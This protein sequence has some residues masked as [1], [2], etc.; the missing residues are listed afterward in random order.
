[1][2]RTSGGGS[3]IQSRRSSLN[4]S[5]GPNHVQLQHATDRINTWRQNVDGGGS[6]SN[7]ASNGNR[8]SWGGTPT[9]SER[10][11]SPSK[12]GRASMNASAATLASEARKQPYLS[13]PIPRSQHPGSP[14]GS[15]VSRG[16]F[17]SNTTT[18]REQKR[19]SAM[20]IP[21]TPSFNLISA[22]SEKEDK[23]EGSFWNLGR[24]RNR[25]SSVISSPLSTNGAQTNG[26]QPRPSGQYLTAPREK[27]GGR[28]SLAMGDLGRLKSEEAVSRR[29]SAGP[30]LAARRTQ[31]LNRQG[32]FER[33]EYLSV[34]KKRVD[35]GVGRMSA[36]MSE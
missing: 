16:T 6:N 2:T 32:S 25:Y 23:V 9:R 22:D 13:S 1:M 31:E 19:T 15:V 5:Q 28:M 26:S 33:K 7:S 21:P 10:S 11:M 30:V 29:R 34:T 24:W 20:S 27:S 3:R 18:P 36:D 12:G 35:S 4:I 8:L 14:T 17:M